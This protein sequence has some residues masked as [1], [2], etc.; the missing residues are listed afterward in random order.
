MRDNVPELVNIRTQSIVIAALL[1]TLLGA[2]VS[3]QNSEC[4]PTPRRDL[5]PDVIAPMAGDDPIWF[6]DGSGGVWQ[7]RNTPVKSVWV[8]ARNVTGALVASGRQINGTES[9]RFRI[10]LEGPMTDAVRF[11]D[12]AAETM[13][14]GSATPEL[15]K[16]RAFVAAYL[17]FPAPGCWEIRSRLG[18]TRRTVVL[19]VK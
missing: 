19:H 5:L 6:I 7:G 4:V 13:I 12:P 15:M 18:A 10:G 8:V 17:F 9:L 1:L 3:A 11:D 2:T 14:P 16:R